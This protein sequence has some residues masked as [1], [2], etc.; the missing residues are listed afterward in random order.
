MFVS[1]S[2]SKQM[3]YSSNCLPQAMARQGAEVHLVC[4]ALFP[5]EESHPT[6]QV[7][8]VYDKFSEGERRVEGSIE[9]YDGIKLHTLPHMR[10]FG[11]PYLVGLQDKLQN[12]D[13]DIVQCFSCIGWVP[14]QSARIASSRNKL[15][16]T[17][18]HMHRSLHRI[19]GKSVPA[20]ST[21]RARAQM[22]RWAGRH[23]DGLTRRCY[24][25]MDDCASIAIEFYGVDP[26]KVKVQP[27]GVDT[28]HFHPAK[29]QKEIDEA[30]ELRSRLGI[31]QGQF[32][33]IYTGR[34]TENKLTGLLAKAIE[35]LAEEGHDVKAVFVGEGIDRQKLEQF[36]HSVVHEFVDHKRLAC[37]YRAADIAVWPTLESMSILDATACGL[38]V[39]GSDVIGEPGYIEGSGLF[40]RRG[41]LDDLKAKIKQLMDPALRR[42]LG[43]AGVKKIAEKYSWDKIA[44]D[45]LQDFREDLST[46]Q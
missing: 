18:A 3:G 33:A 8:G 10:R 32:V 11:H 1:D 40:C 26:S 39:I 37:F 22:I 24:P 21:L 12:I 34:F 14:F 46:R 31:G 2:F 30:K 13:P 6:A 15:F 43:L 25:T 5:F 19:G 35:D 16:Y 29:D 28:S 9:D 4:S 38:P 20:F 23:I 44:R 27:L 36:Q 7:K 45:R 42:E 17:E 41:D